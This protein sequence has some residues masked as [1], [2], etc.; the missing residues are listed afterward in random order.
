MSLPTF[1]KLKLSMGDET[2][3][4]MEILQNYSIVALH[5]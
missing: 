1:G 3:P 2:A 4:S 5:L